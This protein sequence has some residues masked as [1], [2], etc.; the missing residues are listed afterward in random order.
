[1]FYK[2]T[3]EIREKRKSFKDQNYTYILNREK[4]VDNSTTGIEEKGFGTFTLT[5]YT[6][7]IKDSVNLNSLRILLDFPAG[8]FMK[9]IEERIVGIIF[10]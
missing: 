9:W 6:E 3:I 2:R 5:G 10:F 7:C 1:M 4:T 8:E